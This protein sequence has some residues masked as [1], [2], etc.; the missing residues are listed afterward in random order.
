MI[1]AWKTDRIICCFGSA[2]IVRMIRTK[3]ARAHIPMY[4]KQI[5]VC[6]DVD[7]YINYLNEWSHALCTG[8]T[9]S[10]LLY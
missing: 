6:I 5:H 3:A 10:L 9:L 2:W 7:D 4:S 1:T 8:R